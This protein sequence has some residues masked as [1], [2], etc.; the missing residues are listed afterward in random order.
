MV[1]F[2]G[3]KFEILHVLHMHIHTH[4]PLLG[5]HWPGHVTASLCCCSFSHSQCCVFQ[6]IFKVTIFLCYHVCVMCMLL[7]KGEVV[8]GL[9]LV[10]CYE[11]IL[12]F[13]KH[14]AMKMYGEVGV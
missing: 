6:N 10:P 13:A 11:D 5:Y 2:F 4:T 12:Q 1:Y 9:N 7:G 8:P 14:H 3:Q